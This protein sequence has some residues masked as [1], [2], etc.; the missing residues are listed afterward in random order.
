MKSK[1]SVDVLF[2]PVDGP[3]A[4]AAIMVLP[5]AV[6]RRSAAK[7]VADG[8]GNDALESN[9]SAAQADPLLLTPPSSQSMS[10]ELWK[11]GEGAAGED[12]LTADKAQ[13]APEPQK[14]A[15]GGKAKKPAPARAK[16]RNIAM[17]FIEVRYKK[18]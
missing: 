7:N 4:P 12:D 13:V 2:P 3:A 14:A 18:N 10:M 1:A 11:G 15:G 17:L 6:T 8:D 5:P 16:V 9:G